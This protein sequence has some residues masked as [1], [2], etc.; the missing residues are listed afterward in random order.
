MKAMKTKPKEERQ[1]LG[2]KLRN[3]GIGK[4]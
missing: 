2:T 3:N 1:N 4:N